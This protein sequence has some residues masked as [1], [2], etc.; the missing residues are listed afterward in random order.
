MKIYNL[1]FYGF[2]YR[3]IMKFTHKYN[4]HYAPPIYPNGDT[5]LWCKWCGFRETIKRKEKV[6]IDKIDTIPSQSKNSEEGI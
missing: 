6:G 2:L 1:P 5:Q 4:W 3:A